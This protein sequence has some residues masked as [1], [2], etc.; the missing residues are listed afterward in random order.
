MFLLFRAQRGWR[1]ER[2]DRKCESERDR[3]VS[4][5]AV[6]DGVETTSKQ[7]GKRPPV[8]ATDYRPRGPHQ[9]NEHR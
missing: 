9:H 6:W 1:R 2:Q 3:G 4:E 5:N 7:T 8:H